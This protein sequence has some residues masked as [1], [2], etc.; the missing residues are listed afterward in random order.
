MLLRMLLAREGTVAEA[1][2]LVLA[3]GC[4]DFRMH[5]QVWGLLCGRYD[6]SGPQAS[7]LQDQLSQLS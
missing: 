3:L 7:H 1:F 4:N 2:L 6:L 5:L